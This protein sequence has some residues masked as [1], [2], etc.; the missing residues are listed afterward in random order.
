MQKELVSIVEEFI[1]LCHELHGQGQI[2]DKLYEDLTKN[3][4]E[5]LKSTKKAI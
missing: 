3:K 1:K 4:F 5:F 2:D